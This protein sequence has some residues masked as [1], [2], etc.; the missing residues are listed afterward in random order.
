MSDESKLGDDDGPSAQNWRKTVSVASK[1]DIGHVLGITALLA[2]I[3]G[4]I[5]PYGLAPLLAVAALA[6]LVSG[7]LRDGRW[8]SPPAG[9]TVLIA[10]LIGWAMLSALWS[11]NSAGTLGKL[12]RFALLLMAGLAIVDAALR[13]SPDQCRMVARQLTIGLAAGIVWMLLDRLTGGYVRQII[14]GRVLDDVAFLNVYSGSATLAVLFV[15]PLMV[16]AARIHVLAP[17]ALWLLGL[18]VVLSL[19]SSA[20]VLAIVLGGAGFVLVALAPRK[21]P[22]R[23]ASALLSEPL[24]YR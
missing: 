6:A 15:W 4:F 22:S 18:G 14:T 1:F 11:I 9:L 7:R 3:I 20:A 19:I 8:P 2:P 5:A 17:V 24:E 16:R 13:L 12:P 21:D 10:I 23:V